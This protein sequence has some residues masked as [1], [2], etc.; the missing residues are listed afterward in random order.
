MCTAIADVVPIL[1]VIDL[2]ITLAYRTA[3]LVK[4]V[5]IRVETSN[6]FPSSK[7]DVSCQCE[8][9][10]SLGTQSG[11]AGVEVSVWFEVEFGLILS[12][13]YDP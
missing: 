3:V 6:W 7:L 5:P 4:D 8:G 9:S 1:I 12:Q 10:G 13:S 2:V 11:I